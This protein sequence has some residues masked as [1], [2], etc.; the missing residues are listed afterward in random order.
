VFNNIMHVEVQSFC[1]M[2]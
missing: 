2:F 1:I